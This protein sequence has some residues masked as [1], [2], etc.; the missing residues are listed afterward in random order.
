VPS[1]VKCW[2]T[3]RCGHR[4]PGDG[5]IDIGGTAPVSLAV[6]GV[7][8]MMLDA[9]RN[10]GRPLN[11]SRLFGWH[12]A[13]FPTRRSG[14]RKITVGAWRPAEAGPMQ[15]VS[16]PL[17]RQKVHFEA[18]EAGRL[19]DEMTAFPVTLASSAARLSRWPR[20]PLLYHP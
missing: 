12:A 9:T 18:P 8:E 11:E 13:L 10:Y 3:D 19:S 2:T 17:G 16:E 15:V 20:I 7:V 1:R 5:G 4:L 6:E 14:M